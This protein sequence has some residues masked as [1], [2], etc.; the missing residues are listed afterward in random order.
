MFACRKNKYYL[1]SIDYF[2]ECIWVSNLSKTSIRYFSMGYL[3]TIVL[4]FSVHLVNAQSGSI[5]GVVRNTNGDAV[6]FTTVV[7]IKNEVVVLKAQTGLSGD[8]K[9]NHLEAGKYK[10]ETSHVGYS[11]TRILDVIVSEN[12]QTNYKIGLYDECFIVEI[13]SQRQIIN[14]WNLTQGTTFISN[15]LR[16][17]PYKN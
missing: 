17:S 1:L 2:V 6:L 11:M 12:E 16:K 3:L 13:T 4:F 8:F 9:V 10:I 14:P 15:E 7:I 5:Q